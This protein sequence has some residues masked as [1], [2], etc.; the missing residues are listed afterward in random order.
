[1]RLGRRCLHALAV[2]L[3]AACASCGDDLSGSPATTAPPKV[4]PAEPPATAGPAAVVQRPPERIGSEPPAPEV[5]DPADVESTE[6][7]PLGGC[8]SCHVDVEDE[9]KES[10]HLVE[11]VGCIACHGPSDGHIRDENNEVLPDEVFAR[12]DV[13]RLC[14]ECHTCS[15]PK[16][17]K[18]PAD[19]KV[20]TD[21][22]QS[23]S[24]A[25]VD[26][27]GE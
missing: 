14:G 6:K 4:T 3:L 1:M 16:A 2:V 11:E 19:R 15:R 18:T 21:C 23:H 8:G 13:D 27:D 17:A 5:I 22:H 25:P 7:N 24:L 12:E 10:A 9:L 20:C 26:T